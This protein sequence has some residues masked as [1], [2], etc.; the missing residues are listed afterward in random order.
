MRLQVLIALLATTGVRRNLDRPHQPVGQSSVRDADLRPRRQ[1]PDRRSRRRPR[2]GSDR[3]HA[4]RLS[5]DRCAGTD[6]RLCGHTRPGCDGRHGGSARHQ[7]SRGAR[8]S[9]LYCPPRSRSTRGAAA[10]ARL[11]SDRLFEHLER[12]SRA[13]ADDLARRH[14]A[15]D[16]GR[17]GRRRCAGRN[18]RAV[19]QSADGAV[20]RR[21]GSARRYAR[22]A[23]AAADARPRLCR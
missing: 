15:D 22:R 23:A 19:R 11:S 2:C 21:G 17:F 16:D 13:R 10:R 20:L 9:P 7:R 6:K 1:A 3:G 4:H 14:G 8:R 12:R 5:R 18:A